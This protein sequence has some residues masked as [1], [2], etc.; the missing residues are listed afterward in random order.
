MK[1]LRTLIVDDMPLA[2][3]K[4]RQ[5]LEDDAEIDIVG[6]CGNGTETVAKVEELQPELVF[7]DVQMPN[8]DVFGVIDAL[9]PERMPAVVF[10]TAYDEHALQAFEVNALD[11][12]LKPI[13]RS[14]FQKALDRA[15]AQVRRASEHELETRLRALLKIA[16][17]SIYSE[18]AR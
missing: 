9:G 16:R 17:S 7:L 14:R 6:E 5:Y 10:V 1:P 13:G 11:Y 8:L 12:L 15:K 18:K 3:E 4:L 2:R